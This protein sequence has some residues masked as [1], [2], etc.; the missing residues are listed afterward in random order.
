MDSL[1]SMWIQWRV[2]VIEAET[3]DRKADIIW[4]GHGPSSSGVLIW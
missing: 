4:T 3:L 2:L 1:E